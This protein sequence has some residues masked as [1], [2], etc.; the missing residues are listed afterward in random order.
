MFKYI[1]QMRSD[2]LVRLNVLSERESLK[3]K[4]AWA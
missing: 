2:V 1:L 4:E 3:L